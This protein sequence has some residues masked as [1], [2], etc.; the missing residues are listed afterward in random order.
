MLSQRYNNYMKQERLNKLMIHKEHTDKLD[1][2]QVANDF[3]SGDQ[4]RCPFLDHLLLATK[5]VG[6]VGW[7][8]L[9]PYHFKAA[10]SGPDREGLARAGIDLWVFSDTVY[11]CSEVSYHLILEIPG[12]GGGTRRRCDGTEG[13]DESIEFAMRTSSSSA[14]PWIP[15]RMDYYDE[16]TI[17]G[18]TSTRGYTIQA[19]GGGNF[20]RQVHIC[21]D[22]LRN[23]S[24]I[25]FRWMGARGGRED[26]RDIW[27]L[28]SV[29]ATLVVA[30]EELR[31]FE[32]SF[33]N[34]N[35][36]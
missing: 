26:E 36:K 34:G 29:N 1:L 21:G 9:W 33:G 28:G 17:N 16:S 35:L 25:Q 19:V 24:G 31:T 2:K 32:D 13:P 4:H 23:A 14:A 15:I 22:L 6:E 30:N 20:I 11:C 3:V 12:V 18:I 27:A 10:C 8:W 7:V 5:W